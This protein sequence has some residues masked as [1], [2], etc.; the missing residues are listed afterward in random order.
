MTD[1]TP[2]AAGQATA[3]TES[4]ALVSGDPG[5]SE[6]ARSL[7]S[8][9]W[10]ELRR[11]PTF[12]F[13]I[14]L[15]VLFTVMAIVPG[16]FTRTSPS[17]T[18]AVRQTPSGA[19]W[20]G[21]DG[22]GYD[23]YARTIYGARASM[24]VGL[25]ATVITAVVGSLIGIAAA[26]T[27]GWIDSLISRVTDVFFAIPLLLGG[28]LF[29]SAFPNTQDTPYLVVVGKVVLVLGVLGWPSLARLMRGSVLQVKPQEYVQAARALGAGPIRIIRKHIIPN[30]LAP[31]LVVSTINLGVFIVAEASMSFLGIGLVPPAISWG[32]AIDEA[33]GV[34]RV[35]PHMLFFPAAFLSL[36]VLSFIMLGDALRDAFDP[37]SR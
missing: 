34:V 23:I 24:I 19:H 14:G 22:Q 32:V 4:T 36:C 7:A 8:D 2:Q 18:F 3:T 20:F 35:R 1:Q 9:G 27:G 26:Y 17:E 11:K 10:A 25:A 37:K 15:I 13:A 6:R 28:I 12:W 33:I 5:S 29:L 31:V 30:A 16:L 21:T